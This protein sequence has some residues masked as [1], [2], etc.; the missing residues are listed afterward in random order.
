MA[1]NILENV[2]WNWLVRDPA[3]VKAVEKL[4][5]NAERMRDALARG[6]LDATVGEL[7]E[8]MK[9]KRQID[10]GSCPQSF[11]DLAARWQRELA[12]WCFAG[13]GGG[14]FMLLVA[15]DP[16][17]AEALRAKIERDPPNPRARAFDFEVDPVGL[18][19]AVL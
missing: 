8:Y 7:T 16:Q 4:R 15:K 17:A 1:K 10:P 5:A 9:R 18:R 13:A 6:D 19:C 11:D 14:G 3:A 12:A 2:V